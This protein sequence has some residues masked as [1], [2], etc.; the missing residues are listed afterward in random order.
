MPGVEVGALAAERLPDLLTVEEAARVLRIGWTLAYE[1]A[2]PWEATGGREGLP[3]VRVGRLLRVPRHQLDRLLAGSSP[4]AARAR[5]RLLLAPVPAVLHDLPA[6]NSACST[7]TGA[8]G[9]NANETPG[10]SRP[11]SKPRPTR[12]SSC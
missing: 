4:P 12:S 9:P 6:R 8:A 2:G 1:L 3:V 10:T 11:A 7:R 5:P